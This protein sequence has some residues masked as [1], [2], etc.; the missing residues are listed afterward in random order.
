MAQNRHGLPFQ[1]VAVT[2]TAY[3]ARQGGILITQ[4]LEN[5]RGSASFIRLQGQQARILALIQAATRGGVETP[6]ASV[7][8]ETHSQRTGQ[9]PG[10]ALEASSKRKKR[11]YRNYHCRSTF[12]GPLVGVEV[13]RAGAGAGAGAGAE[14][15]PGRRRSAGA[16]TEDA[17]KGIETAGSQ[18]VAKPN[19]KR[20]GERPKTERP[21]ERGRSCRARGLSGVA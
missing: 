19:P 3:F 9:G 13:G 1:K 11:R 2:S 12:G 16:G 20:E 18:G 21:G 14:A 5:R 8:G 10:Q 7:S 6:W 17:S 15:G 4:N